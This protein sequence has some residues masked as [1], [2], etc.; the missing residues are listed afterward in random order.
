MNFLFLLSILSAFASNILGSVVRC[1]NIYMFFMGL[2]LCHHECHSL[3]IVIFLVL[4]SILSHIN[5]VTPALLWTFLA[6]YHIFISISISISSHPFDFQLTYFSYISNYI[7][8]KA[9]LV[10]WQC[11]T[12]KYVTYTHDSTYDSEMSSFLFSTKSDYV[13]QVLHCF[14]HKGT[15][16]K[17]HHGLSSQQELC[18]RPKDHQDIE[19]DDELGPDHSSDVL[20]LEG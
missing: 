4:K 1:I 20:C 13:W 15:W 6:I 18:V 8:R 19:V 17:L 16:Q 5:I 7:S 12:T 11:A 14:F 10:E 3:S 2:S 9:Q